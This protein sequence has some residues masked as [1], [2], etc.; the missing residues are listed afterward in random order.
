MR[1]IKKLQYY[2]NTFFLYKT[3]PLNI[4]KSYKEK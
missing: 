1:L 2:N 4:L 3:Y